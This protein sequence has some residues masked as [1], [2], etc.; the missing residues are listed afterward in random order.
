MF[1][2]HTVH[3][4][5]PPEKVWAITADVANWP[6]FAPQFKSLV[7]IDEGPLRMGSSARVTP[8]GFFGAVWTVTQFEEGRSFAWEAD[9]L[10][11]LH[12]VGDHIV[13]PDGGGTNV[14]LSLDASGPTMLL[15]W[16]ALRRI[17]TR[18]V[19]GE[20]AGLKAYAERSTT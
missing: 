18:N 16:L 20:A 7:R 9:M 3:I 11:G 12:L 1:I 6:A 2:S 17:F 4:D 5:A 13:E 19:R 8:H 15:M 14:T 10:P